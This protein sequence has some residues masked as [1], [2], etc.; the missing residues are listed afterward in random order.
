MNKNLDNLQRN[1]K[2]NIVNG[3]FAQQEEEGD[4]IA[5]EFSSDEDV[6]NDCKYNAVV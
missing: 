2:P 6:G 3:R 1:K 5:N 4:M